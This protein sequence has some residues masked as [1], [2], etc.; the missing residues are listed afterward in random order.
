VVSLPPAAKVVIVGAGVHGLSTAWHLAAEL[1]A[2]RLGTGTDIV[3]IDKT[4]AGASGIACGVVRNNYFRTQ[5]LF[6]QHPSG[7]IGCFTPDGFPVFDRFHDNVTV[8]ADSNTAT[9]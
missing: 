4:G 6:S 9:R 8:L 3:V 5:H 1:E 2:R 7:G